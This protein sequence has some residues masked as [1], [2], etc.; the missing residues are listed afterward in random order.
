M[1]RFILLLL[2][3]ALHEGA[4][5]A[6]WQL[7]NHK[8]SLAKQSPQIGYNLVSNNHLYV[9]QAPL[10]GHKQLGVTWSFHNKCELPYAK[11]IY[12]VDKYLVLAKSKLKWLAYKQSRGK[13]ALILGSGG[14]QL[15]LSLCRGYYYHS[16]LIGKTWRGHPYCDVVYQG[17]VKSLKKYSVLV[18]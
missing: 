9:C 17:K 12:V 5:A 7:P 1:N 15:A 10:W 13:Q 3:C 2:F 18:G 11:K 4:I 16:L 14:S 6:I 8:I